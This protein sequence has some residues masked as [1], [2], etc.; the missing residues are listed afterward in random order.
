MPSA[1]PSPEGNDPSYQPGPQPY[2]EPYGSVPGGPQPQHAPPTRGRKGPLAMLISGIACGLI[3]V[4]LIL[5]GAVVS[6]GGAV[7]A[8]DG[9]V[10]LESGTPPHRDGQA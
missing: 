3:G 10:M 6:I 4:V 9:Q 8:A 7:S 5:I 2:P 1:Y